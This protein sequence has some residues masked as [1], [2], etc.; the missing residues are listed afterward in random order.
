[1][2]HPASFNANA[3][4]PSFGWQ[5]SLLLFGLL[6]LTAPGIATA[7]PHCAATPFKTAII[8]SVA[9]DNVIHLE[10]GERVTLANIK[11]ASRIEADFLQKRLTGRTVTLYPTGRL[12]DRHN[13]LIRQLYLHPAVPGEGPPLWLQKSLV[14][15]GLAKVFAL[16]NTHA[17]ATTLLAEESVARIE[18]RGQWAKDGEF[19]IRSAA[20]I[21]SLN[22]LPQGSF[23][24]VRG[25][26]KAVGG[27]SRN[28]YL[29]FSDNWK[30]D[31]T[32]MLHTRLLRRKSS[33]WPKLKS[34]V[35]KTLIIRGWLDHWNGPMI[36]LEVP[37]MLTVE[38]DAD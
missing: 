4:R 14:A 30:T 17:C 36:R 22:R 31:F 6:L 2:R 21:K 8:K 20:D 7:K 29:N 25:Q 11:L 26:L 1:M 24:L 18:Q 37:E 27:G 23:L 16:P 34:L 9:A 15:K 32:A 38:P 28:T 19:K 3:R 10:S 33:R 5:R 13:R 35:G 12:K